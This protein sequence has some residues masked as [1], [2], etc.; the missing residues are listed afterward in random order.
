MSIEWRGTGANEHGVDTRSGNTIVKVDT[1]YF[2]PTEVDTLLG[3]AT[4]ARVKLG[5]KLEHSFSDLVDEMVR[6]DLQ[7]AKRDA[8]IARG[9]FKTYRHLE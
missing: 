8:A 6:E 3:D 5:W 1:H 7:V 2:R 9:G 4:K